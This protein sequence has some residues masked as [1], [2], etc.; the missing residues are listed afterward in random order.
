MSA[1]G[2]SR[3]EFLQ[4]VSA[5]TIGF[6]LSSL[7]GCK[8]EAEATPPQ[9]LNA[10]LRIGA[11]DRVTVLVGQSEVGQGIVTTLAQIIASELGAEWSA[12]DYEIVTGSPEHVHPLIYSGEQITGGSTSTMAF[13]EPAR[14][15]AATARELLI[16]A[17]AK[18]L[19]VDA[20]ELIA[21]DGFIK[22]ERSKRAL[23]FSQLSAL[24]AT[25]PIPAKVE[26]RPLADLQFVGAPLPRLDSLDKI[27]GKAIYGVD[28]TRP[29]M[30]F[31]AIKH[32]PVAGAAV[33]SIERSSLEGLPGI[34]AVVPLSGSVGVVA[35]Q[36]W[37][38]MRA[39]QKL[40][41]TFGSSPRSS[42]G[43][44]EILK[45]LR[46]AQSRT[47]A[48]A[49][50]KGDAL[51]ALRSAK[52]VHRAEYFVPYLAHAT[53]EPM[54]C[55]ADVRENEVEIWAPTQAPTLAARA[56]SEVT[57]IHQK[58]ITVHVTLAGGGFGRRGSSD[59]IKQA[60]AL[61]QAVRRPVKLI[62]SREEDI[63]HDF[64][65]PAML[66]RLEAALDD[67]SRRPL[68]WHQRNCGPGVW[69][70]SRPELVTGPVDPL[71]V[72]GATEDYYAIAHKRVDYVMTE[73]GVPIGFWRSV[74][75]SH[76]TFFV[77][78]FIDELAHL[79]GADPY[80]YRRDLLSGNELAIRVLDRAAALAKW[81]QPLPQGHGRGIAFFRSARWQTPVA[82]V[83]EV[84]KQQSGFVVTRVY[85]AADC[86]TLI[87]PDVGRAQ[88]EGGIIFG[89]TAAL[90]GKISINAGR[91]VQSNFHDYPL[92]SLQATPR[93]EVDL[94]ASGGFVGGLGELGTPAIAPAVTNALFAATGKRLRSL[95]LA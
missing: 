94:F 76:N 41:V 30:L 78:S 5:V 56:A 19:E 16:Q 82:I 89:L 65:R 20:S 46:A 52:Q 48:P 66:A 39:V 58:H 36:Y 23:R 27:T 10:W 69:K 95:P 80:I 33:E 53:M 12:V 11:E 2:T 84:V 64:Y 3:R 51:A 83:A 13:F 35:D 21:A 18:K 87:N 15:A 90:Q 59:F 1:R 25:L 40:N 50:S 7:A 45:E 77:E 22:H 85:C 79:A 6:S 73:P 57:G 55:V 28:V 86:G 24:A 68:A 74:G 72:E 81:D 8:G 34:V 61:S 62:W 32:S 29:G 43:D 42:I 92:L 26:L 70:Y 31:A 71:A 17:C 4:A 63:Q 9:R 88:L 44:D 14:R 47:A 91:V 93:I 49:A 37:R 38:A 75:Y 60:V 54:S 67:E